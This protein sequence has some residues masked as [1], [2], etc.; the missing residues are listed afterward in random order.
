V[1]RTFVVASLAALACAISATAA[2]APVRV[3]RSHGVRFDLNGPVLTVALLRSDAR[4]ELWGERIRAVCSPTFDYRRARRVAVRAVQLWPDGQAELSYTFERDISDRV[5]WC[6]LEDEGGGDVAAVDFQHFIAVH[7]DSPKDRQIGHRLR[8]YLWRN[9]G[10]RPWLRQVR[11][12]VVDRK[13]IAVA[14]GLRRDGPGRRSAREICQL[15][16]GADVADFTPG[17]TV[18]GR[19]DVVVRACAARK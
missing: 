8:R 4:A 15:I 19:N 10:S 2:P 14:T 13:V 17:H 9:A 12:I 18:F 11:A 1:R 16:Q 5:T 7:A 3:D 6:L